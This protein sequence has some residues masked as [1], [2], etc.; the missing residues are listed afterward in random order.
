MNLGFHSHVPAVKKGNQL[1]T[2]GSQGVFIDSLAPYWEKIICF[3]H[4][5]NLEEVIQC[6]YLIRSNNIELE[7][8]GPHLSVPMRIIR[9]KEYTS[10]L[11]NRRGDIDALLI[12]GPSPLLPAMANRI[13]KIPKILLLIASYKNGIDG[14]AQPIWRK[15]LIRMWCHWNEAQQ[16]KIAKDNLTFVNSAVLFNQLNPEVP[17]LIETRTTTIYKKDIYI[18]GDTCSNTPYRILFSGRIASEKGLDDIIKAL[19]MVLKQGINCILDIVGSPDKAEYWEK[20]MKKVRL[21]GITDRV[22]YHG[23]KPVGNELFTHYRKADV[24]I[25]ASR[26]SEGF[27]RT[28]WE[29][30]SQCTPV[31]AT[32]VGSIP[33]YL[34]H[35]RDALLA[36]PNDPEKLAGY[37]MRIFSDPILRKRLIHHG[38]KLARNNTLESRA[39]EMMS[40]ILERLKNNDGN[41][42][43]EI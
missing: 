29:A 33:F 2:L 18:R 11:F 42:G 22:N 32:N 15:Q 31:I 35:E 28:I 43:S 8:I 19:E 23:F 41:I 34:E 10:S 9:A 40:H 12:R 37:L 17:K 24:F 20:L 1:F 21:L 27:P 14:L 3:L 6:N 39:K 26:A 16:L 5:P 30:F 25:I 13:P 38:L 36:S 7:I 4:S